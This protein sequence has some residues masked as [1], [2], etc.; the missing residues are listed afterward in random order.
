[1]LTIPTAISSN[2][3]RPRSNQRNWNRCTTKWPR[4]PVFRWWNVVWWKSRV[5][6]ISL[7]GDSTDLMAKRFIHR[8]WLQWLLRFTAMRALL[9]YVANWV[10]PNPFVRRCSAG[11][12]SMCCQITQMIMNGISRSCEEEE[13][14]GSWLL[15]MISASSLWGIGMMDI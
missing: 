5:Q 12:C 10:W 14:S 7:P 13:A 15:P 3:E 6:I 1:M 8:P 2:L 9:T 11:W 4:M